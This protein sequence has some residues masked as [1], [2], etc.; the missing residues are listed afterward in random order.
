MRTMG[1][2]IAL[3]VGALFLAPLSV[4]AEGEA[5]SRIDSLEARMIALEDQLAAS[6]STV[7]AQRELLKN[8]AG[9]GV[10]QGSGA[11]GFLSG[12]QIGG[13]V[14]SS[15][16]Y[17]FNNPDAGQ[18]TFVPSGNTGTQLVNQF[19]T[20]HNSFTLDAVKLEIGKPTSG[21]GTA[22]FQFDLLF[23][24]NASI[25]SAGGSV[26]RSGLRGVGREPGDTDVF[27]QEAYVAYDWNGVELQFGKFETLLGY[28]VLD[29][30]Y[31]LHVTHGLL[32]T[33]AIPLF[34]TGLL[35]SGNFGEGYSWAAGVVNGF[36]DSADLGDNKGLIGR[37][38][39]SGGNTEILL[40]GFLGEEQTRQSLDACGGPA[41]PGC[42]LVPPLGV[43]V[44]D[45]NDERLIID[46]VLQHKPNEDMTAWLNADY[47]R[48]KGAD[49]SSI[50]APASSGTAHWYGVA[51]G[52]A[53]DMSERVTMAIR[54]EYFRDEGTSRLFGSGLFANPNAVG[55]TS[56]NLK[57]TD[58]Y[59]GTLT[60]GYR[61][62]ENLN[63]RLEYRRD[64]FDIR[65]SRS[66]FGFTEDDGGTD[67]ARDIGIFEVAY[68]FD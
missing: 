26:D 64:H 41:A 68:T 66:G 8:Q 10:G 12:L 6:E 13:Y 59:E 47:G 48:E 23:G 16:T 27:V 15:Y 4:H 57:E 39:W 49:L 45:E 55:V 9:P 33:W 61:L 11:D 2:A 22:G 50:N 30:P 37:V 19:N 67:S 31:N 58:V 32:F 40:N 44:S 18:S 29:S 65:G 38:G 52:L 63:A 21:P 54:G 1:K 5:V 56:R 28:E 20:D 51:G 25:L 60:L 42:P 35:A 14:S 53:W 43:T 3:A 36:N 24:E 17:N 46:L 34:H 62:T 7:A